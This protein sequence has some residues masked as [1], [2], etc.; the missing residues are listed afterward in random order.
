[1]SARAGETLAAALLAD[2]VTVFG[3]AASSGRARA[4]YCMMGSCFECRV[5]ID[6]IENQQACMTGIREG[7]IAETSTGRPLPHAPATSDSEAAGDDH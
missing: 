5:I 1:M 3:H 2:G 6:G 4:P 7:L